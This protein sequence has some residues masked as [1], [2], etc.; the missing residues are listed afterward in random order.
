M[1][2]TLDIG[3]SN[4]RS[5]GQAARQAR[6]RKNLNKEREIAHLETQN[7]LDSKHDQIDFEPVISQKRPPHKQ[8]VEVLIQEQP[9]VRH[10]LPQYTV[11]GKY[12]EPTH[13]ISRNYQKIPDSALRSTYD[14]SKFDSTSVSE[15][16]LN[17]TYE[18]Q[19]DQ[20]KERKRIL[21]TLHDVELRAFGKASKITRIRLPTAHDIRD[22]M[23]NIPKPI[24]VEHQYDKS[25]NLIRHIDNVKL[26][27]L[28]K[29][30]DLGDYEAIPEAMRRYLES[31]KDEILIVKKLP[32][33]PPHSYQRPAIEPP[34]YYILSP[35]PSSPP[36]SSSPPSSPPPSSLSPPSP[37]PPPPSPPSA[38]TK[39][40]GP[41]SMKELL[42]SMLKPSSKARR[43]R[44]TEKKPKAGRKRIGRR[45]ERH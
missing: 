7:Q 9:A 37:P 16:H 2:S 24:V 15:R 33:E 3:L 8:K 42:I 5:R 10:H 4:A 21:K 43:K 23:T 30:C 36:P 12:V 28:W 38:Q 17:M 29:M 22:K 32:I 35:P 25:T 34:S 27:Q 31:R 13:W 40:N 44:H 11:G 26:Q 20:W 18:K 39:S 6:I 14:V 41:T 45:V 19:T 1:Q